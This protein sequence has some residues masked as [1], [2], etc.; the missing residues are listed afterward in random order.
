M[1]TTERDRQTDT[2]APPEGF[3]RRTSR[4]P[5]LLLALIVLGAFFAIGYT[6]FTR[7][8]VYYRTP[9]EVLTMPGQHVRLSG[10]VVSG[11]ITRDVEANVV[12]F[13]VTDGRA[14]VP[15]RFVG[16]APDTLK[17]GADAVAEGSLTG[18]GTFHAEKLFA[19][20]PSKFQTK[21]GG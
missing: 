11:S 6:M 1:D 15:V 19:K 2:S 12:S 16:P 13:E 7:S 17:D 3:E 8:V 21:A 10:R 5:V 14:T 20:C 4:A 18:D 9:T